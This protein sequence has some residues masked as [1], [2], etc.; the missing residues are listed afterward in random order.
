MI[1][2]MYVSAINPST[3]TVVTSLVRA[4]RSRAT[5]MM[6]SQVR[7]AAP[8]AYL[9]RRQAA[10]SSSDSSRHDGRLG[11]SRQALSA[12]MKAATKVATSKVW[13]TDCRRGGIAP[14]ASSD[15]TSATAARPGSSVPTSSSHTASPERRRRPSGAR[16]EAAKRR[17]S[18]RSHSRSGKNITRATPRPISGAVQ[19]CR[20]IALRAASTPM[21]Y[22][23]AK[24][25]TS[26][27]TSLAKLRHSAGDNGEATLRVSCSLNWVTRIFSIR[28][29]SCLASTESSLARAI[30][31]LISAFCWFSALRC[32]LTS[33]GSTVPS[34][35]SPSCDRR[36]STCLS[37]GSSA[38]CRPSASRWTAS[39]RS[40]N[41]LRVSVVAASSRSSLIDR[42]VFSAW[43][44][45]LAGSGSGSPAWASAIGAAPSQANNSSH[46]NDRTTNEE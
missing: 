37:C 27:G 40:D 13:A 24:R 9:R 34:A 16:S 31:A 46:D 10:L 3:A 32:R 15:S 2:A 22:R 38:L 25:S 33:G 23:I 44:S 28:S 14:I 39:A 45:C 21:W 18:A 8:Q 30:C 29:P 20:A 42:K 17:P 6:L 41:A 7:P 11:T 43:A 12:A 36:A 5:S 19:P 1:N 26:P 35:T 4:A